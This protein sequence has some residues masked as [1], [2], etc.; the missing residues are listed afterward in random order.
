MQQP[1]YEMQCSDVEMWCSV[2]MYDAVGELGYNDTS[3]E[4]GSVKCAAHSA[5]TVQHTLMGLHDVL[6]D[7]C[8][9]STWLHSS[10]FCAAYKTLF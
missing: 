8:L 10:H 2:R 1:I 4:C 9:G 5:C 7:L 3:L 6:A